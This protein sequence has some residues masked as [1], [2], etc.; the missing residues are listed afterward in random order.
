MFYFSRGCCKLTDRTPALCKKQLPLSEEVPTERFNQDSPPAGWVWGGRGA[1]WRRER[2]SFEG[3]AGAVGP[4]ADLASPAAGSF[5]GASPSMRP[6]LHS[7]PMWQEC[8]GNNQT[9]NRDKNQEQQAPSPR[10]SYSRLHTALPRLL[11]WP[12]PSHIQGTGQ[13]LEAGNRICY[14]GEE[15]RGE[16][17][18]SSLK[19]NSGVHNPS[20]HLAQLRWRGGREGRS[21]EPGYTPA[22]TTREDQGEKNRGMEMAHNGWLCLWGGDGLQQHPCGGLRASVPPT[23]PSSPHIHSEERR[24]LKEDQR[25][26]LCV[27]PLFS[28]EK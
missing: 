27:S 18:R 15:R 20:L 19:E 2:E 7:L 24:G 12:G 13:E 10:C 23:P 9:S 3:K 16:G 17:R 26:A 25:T 5:Y 4:K 28:G 6:A 8:R 11:S 22:P 1:E 21:K 14:R